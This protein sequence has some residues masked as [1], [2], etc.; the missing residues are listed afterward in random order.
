MVTDSVLLLEGSYAS[1]SP[2][3]TSDLTTLDSKVQEGVFIA[4]Q[5][6]TQ[7]KPLA[8]VWWG[9][10]PVNGAGMGLPLPFQLSTNG[11]LPTSPII[12]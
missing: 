1:W 8:C 11:V 7:D 10:S 6:N 2:F 9:N 12:Y 5:K 3:K 4:A